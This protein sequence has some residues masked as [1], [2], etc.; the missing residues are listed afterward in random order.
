MPVRAVAGLLGLPVDFDSSTDTV[1]LGTSEKQPSALVSKTNSGTNEYSW[2]IRESEELK[3][4]GDS[5]IQEYQNG[6]AWK[7]WNGSAS[8]S[9]ERVLYFDLSGHIEISFTA[10]SDIA[11]KVYVYDQ[12]YNVLTSFELT[13]NAL[14]PK[15]VNIAGASKIAFGANGPA[16]SKGMLKILDATVK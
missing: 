3:I 5:G 2:I 7:I 14:T 9:R 6:I 1:L 12:D 16:G 15:T 13:P 11:A 10:W 4:T 8:V